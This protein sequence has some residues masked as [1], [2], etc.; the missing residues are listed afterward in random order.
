MPDLDDELDEALNSLDAEADA[1]ELAAEA[2]G[3]E[4]VKIAADDEE[5]PEIVVQ[6]DKWKI[7]PATLLEE[8]DEDAAERGRRTKKKIAKLQ[9]AGSELARQRDAEAAEKRNAIAFAQQ[10]RARAVRAEAEAAKYQAEAFDAMAAHQD[11][12]A[13][14]ATKRW[15]AAAKAGES[16]NASKA[17]QEL[18]EA[19]SKA[20]SLKEKAVQAKELLKAAELK[21]KEAPVVQQQQQ[22]QTAPVL[23]PK[24]QGWLRA[25]P[26]FGMDNQGNGK[27]ELSSYALKIHAALKNKGVDLGSDQYFTLL[28]KT[29]KAKFPAKFGVAQQARSPQT[30]R[31]QAAPAATQQVKAGKTTLNF[32]KGQMATAKALGLTTS[33]QL[34]AYHNE[35]MNGAKE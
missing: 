7:D 19:T 13:A 21:T 20:L 6:D 24:T 3:E 34:Q 30:V 32:T 33:R 29:M 27:D 4:D 2:G 35:I 14:S 28:D 18:A 25:N 11:A 10:E 26:W 22:V 17:N 15:E 31:R 23:D 9:A 8:P 1:D 12:L 16:E 5:E